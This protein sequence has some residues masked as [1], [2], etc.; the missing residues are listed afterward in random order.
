[1]P[2]VQH[3]TAPLGIAPVTEA[4]QL[5]VALA[6]PRLAGYDARTLRT[7]GLAYAELESFGAVERGLL[8]VAG[9]P[10]LHT[11]SVRLSLAAAPIET[12]GLSLHTAVLR[13]LS[14]CNDWLGEHTPAL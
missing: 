4:G 5:T 1:M 14:A 7:P 8:R 10:V 12:D 3:T 11:I 2:A 6:D 13:A 9:A